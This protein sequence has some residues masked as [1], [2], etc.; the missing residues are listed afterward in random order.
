MSKH[1]LDVLTSA[2][3]G[4]PVDI[5]GLLDELEKTRPELAA[6]LRKLGP[7]NVCTKLV[8]MVLAQVAAKHGARFET[9]F[10]NTEPEGFVADPDAVPE[11]TEC[12][13]VIAVGEHTR[14]AVGMSPNGGM[15]FYANRYSEEYAGFLLDEWKRDVERGY[16]EAVIEAFMALQGLTSTTL[17]KAEGSVVTGK[18]KDGSRVASVVLA[19]DLRARVDIDLPVGETCDTVDDALKAMLAMMGV[20]RTS[21]FS[22]PGSGATHVGKRVRT[23][24]TKVPGKKGKK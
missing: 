16:R 24:R 15:F 6:K 14:L 13:G 10:V 2:F 11:G 5:E 23:G 22:R 19:N 17:R 18:R 3:T 4:S 9:E 1:Y 20:S 21:T 12:L 7:R 8:A